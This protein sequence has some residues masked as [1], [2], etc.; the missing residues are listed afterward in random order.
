MLSGLPFA[1]CR[2]VAALLV[3]GWAKGIRAAQSADASAGATASSGTAK[4]FTLR[5]DVTLSA[6]AAARLASPKEGIVVSASF[7]GEPTPTARRHA[8]EDG[9]AELGS[10][11]VEIPGRDGEA[12][13]HGTTASMPLRWIRGPVQLNVNV[14]SARHSSP[15]NVLSCDIFEGPLEHAIG[16]AI[17]LHCSLITENQPT[18]ALK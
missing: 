17:P 1:R 6:K 11:K 12:V 13:L 7:E 16:Q 4:A 2:V 15:D 8:G 5:V 3:F 18:K 10:S 9:H 14:F